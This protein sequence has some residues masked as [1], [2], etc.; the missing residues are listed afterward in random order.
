[1]LSSRSQLELTLN[2]D[3]DVK[4][5]CPVTSFIIAESQSPGCVSMR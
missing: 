5:K 2:F 4:D 1:M 3:T